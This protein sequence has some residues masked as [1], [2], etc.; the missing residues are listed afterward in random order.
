MNRYSWS[1]SYSIEAQVVGEWIESLEDNSTT[2]IVK[3]AKRQDSPAHSI[4]EWNDSKAA[5][6]HRLTQAATMRASLRVEVITK[7]RKKP[8]HIP[9]FIASSERGQVVPTLEASADELTEAEVRCLNQMRTF[10][11]RHIGLGVARNVIEAI[12]EAQQLNA[13]RSKKK[14]KRQAR[15]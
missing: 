10:K 14:A 5:A 1:K 15:S 12:D 4:F 2:G 7:G 11:Q 8:I 13:R 3:A 6:Q 9:A